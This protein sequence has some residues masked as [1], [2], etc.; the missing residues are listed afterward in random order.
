MD[1]HTDFYKMAERMHMP[2]ERREGLRNLLEEEGRKGKVPEWRKYALA[3]A[4][5]LCFL[6]AGG[7]AYAAY[8]LG[9]FQTFFR[10]AESE[11]GILAELSSQAKM[12][13]VTE[14]N[15]KY[16]LSVLA[17]LY[18]KDS[19]MGLMICALKYKKG[20]GYISYENIDK[21]GELDYYLTKDGEKSI[22]FM[23]QKPNGRTWKNF[24]NHRFLHFLVLGD[25]DEK[26]SFTGIE[27][28]YMREKTKDGA[29]LIG[30]RYELSDGAEP[31]NLRVYEDELG[32]VFGDHVVLTVPLPK[33]RSQIESA[34]FVSKDSKTEVVL[35]PL[36]IQIKLKE[37]KTAEE[38]EDFA[39]DIDLYKGKEKRNIITIGN[40]SARDFV[41]KDGRIYSRTFVE[42]IDIKE[43]TEIRIKGEQFIKK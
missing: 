38:I 8:H 41:G 40:D 37:K 23:Y 39:F 34:H 30:L 10:H 9:W 18:D 29:Y 33:V 16:K 31:R 12:E 27:T 25:D 36:G 4:L 21:Y 28:Y 13:P 2:E 5:V 32:R 26:N 11:Q 14:E 24:V 42:L 1:K 22:S 43:I 35:S 6:G 15:E 20:D 17:N 3:A 7:T 19:E